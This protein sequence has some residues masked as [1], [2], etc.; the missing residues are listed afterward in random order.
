MQKLHGQVARYQWGTTDA[1]SELLGIP[2]DGTPIAELWLGAHPSAPSSLGR[3]PLDEALSDDPSLL[4]S[5]AERFGGRL[6][7]LMKVLSARHALSLQ[8]HPSREQA[9]E[10]FAAEE[11]RGVPR[12]SPVR[13]YID[14]W[15]KPEI[16]V[17]LSEFHTLAGFRNP[18]HTAELFEA[19]GVADIAAPVLGPLSQRQGEAALQEVFLD[20]LTLTGER[21]WMVDEVLAAAV[22]HRDDPDAVGEFARTALQLDEAFPGDPGIL[23]ALLL[24]RVVLEPG[25]AL[26]VQAGLMHSHLSGT[27]IEVMANSDNVVRGALTDKHIAIDELVRI[28]DFT[29]GVPEVLQ[30][31]ESAPGV[32]VYPTQAREFD[33]WRLEVTPDTPVLLPA[34]GEPRIALLTRGSARFRAGGRVLDLE[35][36]DSVFVAADDPE[37]EVSGDAQVF[38][39]GPGMT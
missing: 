3:R 6:P 1:I 13:V 34:R 26:F 32:W 7:Y 18:L 20:I 19:L 31:V 2:T 16:M 9:E 23:A 22:R 28:V 17:A 38:L 4:G 33:V 14:D 35:Q 25:E 36:G 10:G 15:P 37:V 21:R 27:G 39:S 29:A 8:A 30:S 5:A 24:N 12:R 11:S